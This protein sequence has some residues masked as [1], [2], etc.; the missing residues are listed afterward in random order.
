LGVLKTTMQ[1]ALQRSGLPH[2]AMFSD[3][4]RHLEPKYYEPGTAKTTTSGM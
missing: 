3:T 1:F 2:F 4:G